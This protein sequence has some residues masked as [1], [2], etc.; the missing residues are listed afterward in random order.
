M[1][2]FSSDLNN[3]KCPVCNRNWVSLEGNN[4]CHE[5]AGHYGF[6]YYVWCIIVR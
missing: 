5:K 3:I 1:G 4:H 6:K 2:G